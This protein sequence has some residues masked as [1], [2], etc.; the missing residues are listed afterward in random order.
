MSN[1]A[2][3]KFQAGWFI[4]PSSG[5]IFS[6]K[7]TVCLM[8][9]TLCTINPLRL[10]ILTLLGAPDQCACF[11]RISPTLQGSRKEMDFGFNSQ[12]D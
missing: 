6:P 4:S 12:A 8:K 10:T 5:K 2:K 11:Y 1:S 7:R 3:R 9:K